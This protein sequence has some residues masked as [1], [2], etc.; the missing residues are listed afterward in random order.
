M[1]DSGVVVVGVVGGPSS[2]DT[3]TTESP[4]SVPAAGD[5]VGGGIVANILVGGI[6]VV[7][8]AGSAVGAK[9]APP[10]CDGLGTAVPCAPS[11]GAIVTV[12][13]VVALVEAGT[14]VSVGVMEPLLDFD[15]FF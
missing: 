2:A 13:S 8:D 6:V 9:A 15:C 11:L 10:G 5:D 12:G 1:A 7:V 3:V 14:T 4:L